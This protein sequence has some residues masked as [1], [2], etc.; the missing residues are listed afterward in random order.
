MNRSVYHRCSNNINVPKKI[1]IQLSSNPHSI[2]NLRKDCLKVVRIV[3]TFTILTFCCLHQPG[4]WG[5]FKDNSFSLAFLLT[6]CIL[7]VFPNN[8]FVQAIVQS[9]FVQEFVLSRQ[10]QKSC[11]SYSIL[12]PIMVRTHFNS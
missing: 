10:I 5:R 11:D 1:S 4:C 12:N 3:Q 6:L 7:R 9:N 2:E 8:I